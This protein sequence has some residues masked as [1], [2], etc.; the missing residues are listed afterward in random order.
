MPNMLNNPPGITNEG[1]DQP[2][3]SRSNATAST[4]MFSMVVTE[5]TSQLSKGW[6][7]AVAPWNIYPMLVTED[8][9]QLFSGWLNTL[10]PPNIY[11]M[12]V[13]EDTSHREMS[14]L[15]SRLAMKSSRMFVIPA[16]FHAAISRVSIGPQSAGP[17]EQHVSHVAEP[18]LTAFAQLDTA[19]AS[20]ASLAKGID[21]HALGG[22]SRAP[23]GGVV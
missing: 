15:K 14:T 11:S 7:K 17:D 18:N 2:V 10:A 6:L 5:E 16:V 22:P 9:F 3:M 4:N 20:W 19:A 1:V 21:V 13:T 12:F 23:A 8:T